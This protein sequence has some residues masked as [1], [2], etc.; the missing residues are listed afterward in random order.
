[1]ERGKTGDVMAVTGE[2]EGRHAVI[3]QE[4]QQNGSLKLIQLQTQLPNLLPDLEILLALGNYR[5]PR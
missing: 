2:R 4:G 5:S 3:A 1:M